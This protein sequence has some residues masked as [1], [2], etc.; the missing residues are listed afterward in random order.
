MNE[1]RAWVST[2][3]TDR[4]PNTDFDR[5]P[6]FD[7]RSGE[8]LWIVTTAHK[9]NPAV[10]TEASHTPMLDRETLLSVAG[11]GCY[12]CEKVYTPLLATRRCT[13]EPK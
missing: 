4:I 5:I 9:V 11:P 7:P 13:G 10:W 1:E 8:H 6:P 12:Y 2:G 3:H